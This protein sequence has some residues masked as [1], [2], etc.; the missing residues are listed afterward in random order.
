MRMF[1]YCIHIVIFYARLWKASQVPQENPP[2]I[3]ETRAQYLV[4]EDPLEKKIT[5]H[6]SIL[7]W[8]F[9]WTEE[10]GRSQSTGLQR[11]RPD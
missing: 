5:T 6:S 3:Q 7:A 1:T 9:P 11:V 4:Q 8:E 2:A 10:S